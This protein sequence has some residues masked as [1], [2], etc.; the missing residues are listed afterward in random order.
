MTSRS[1]SSKILDVILL[2]VLLGTTG[3]LAWTYLRLN[4]VETELAQTRESLLQQVSALR[5]ETP[6]LDLSDASLDERTPLD[7]NLE[8]GGYNPAG[9]D[10]SPGFN[11]DKA[12]AAEH[13]QN[14]QYGYS[15]DVP[16]NK[17]WGNLEYRLNPYD[18][19]ENKIFFGNIGSF[20]GCGWLREWSLEASDPRSVQDAIKQLTS[21]E[22]PLD[23][24]KQPSRTDIAGHTAV[25]Y[26]LTG[27]CDTTYTEVIGEDYNYTLSPICD[28]F[29]KSTNAEEILGSL[30]IL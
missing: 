7:L 4:S 6:E 18:E 27:L 11:L 15:V 3:V 28:D 9:P 25:Q 22:P 2:I 12:N 5:G 1:N 29:L 21:V 24:L 19:F 23:F 8:S 17:A 13:Y 26:T 16:F 20:E 30:E 10:C 14:T